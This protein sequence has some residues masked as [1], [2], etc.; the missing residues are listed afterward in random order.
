MGKII[1]KQVQKTPS[2]ME[3]TYS[4]DVKLT[5]VADKI[6]ADVDALNVKSSKLKTP[7]QIIDLLCTHLHLASLRFYSADE[8]SNQYQSPIIPKYGLSMTMLFMW[9]HIICIPVIYRNSV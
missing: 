3:D 1:A 6:K 4:N 5:D 9:V 2:H 7:V 8:W